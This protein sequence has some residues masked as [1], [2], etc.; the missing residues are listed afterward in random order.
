M[1]NAEKFKEVFGFNPDVKACVMP[2]TVCTY[3]NEN[4]EISSCA[5]CDL[6]NW[7]S[8]EYKPCFRL[9]KDIDDGK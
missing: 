6:R 1:T 9:R 7:F 8:K 4:S 3:A 5:K 2:H